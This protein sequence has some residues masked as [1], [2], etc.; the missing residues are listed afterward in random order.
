MLVAAAAGARGNCKQASGLGGGR[1]LCVDLNISL[2]SHSNARFGLVKEVWRH[3]V[4][5]QHA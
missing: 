2:F 3:L 4:A 5:A 1:D